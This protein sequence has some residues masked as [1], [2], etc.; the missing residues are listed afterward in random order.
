MPDSVVYLVDPKILDYNHE[1]SFRYREDGSRAYSGGNPAL[2]KCGI[3][4]EDVFRLESQGIPTYW[5]LS[6]TTKEGV[7][8][9]RTQA[10]AI[11]APDENTRFGYHV[12]WQNL[13]QPLDHLAEIVN[14]LPSLDGFDS[15]E[16]TREKISEV[17]EKAGVLIEF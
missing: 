5:Y 16:S 13:D 11:Y 4:L 12:I 10:L 15:F 14:R 8:D 7:A 17:L 6:K 3:H 1:A 2:Q 9:A